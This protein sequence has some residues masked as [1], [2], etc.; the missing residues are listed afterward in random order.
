MAGG[1]KTSAKHSNVVLFRRY[2]ETQAVTRVINAKDLAK[3]SRIAEDPTLRP[4][5]FL[6]VPQNAIS[7]FERLIPFTSIAWLFAGPWGRSGAH[8]RDCNLPRQLRPDGRG[9]AG[10][11]GADRGAARRGPAHDAGGAG[12]VDSGAAGAAD[13]HHLDA[14]AAVAR[15]LLPPLLHALPAGR[16]RREPPPVRP[17]AEQLLRLRQGRPYPARRGPRLLL[18]HPDALGVAQRRLHGARAL[19][20]GRTGR[21]L[22][23]AAVAEALGPARRRGVRTTTSPPRGW[24]PIGSSAATAAGRR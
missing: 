13:P 12:Q 8:E 16:R 10:G 4:G 7:K 3:P 17:G 21:R 9:R 5:D 11:R 2:D 1:F 23:G 15:A 24:S 20:A 14:V 6:F 18:L 19:R 22:H